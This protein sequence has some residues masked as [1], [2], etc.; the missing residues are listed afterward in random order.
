MG[1]LSTSYKP[2]LLN[3]ELLFAFAM[4]LCV[5]V[6]FSQFFGTGFLSHDFLLVPSSVYDEHFLLVPIAVYVQALCFVTIA[7]N[8]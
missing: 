4:E 3:L 1:L 5:S 7:S 8:K 2:A 6:L